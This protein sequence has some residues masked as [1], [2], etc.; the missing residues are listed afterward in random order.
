MGKGASS[1][2][3]TWGPLTLK[4]KLLSIAPAVSAGVGSPAAVSLLPLATDY[5]S[6][7]FYSQSRTPKH[8]P[9]PSS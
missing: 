8:G 1:G 2:T 6:R 3:R 4:P 7:K 5:I 9:P